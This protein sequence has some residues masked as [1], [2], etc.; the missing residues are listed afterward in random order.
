MNFKITLRALILT[1][2]MIVNM[3]NNSLRQVTA[4]VVFIVFDAMTC[5]DTSIF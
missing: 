1:H 2:K 4:G 3:H 5:S